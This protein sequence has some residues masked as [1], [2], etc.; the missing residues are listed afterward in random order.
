L[1]VDS[2]V[3]GVGDAGVAES[4]CIPSYIQVF[5]RDCLRLLN[6]SPASRDFLELVVFEAGSQLTYLGENAF[7][8]CSALRRLCFPASVERL[9]SRRFFGC[10]HLS[11]L[12][13]E[14][15]SNLSL[16]TG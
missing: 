5:A 16:I 2:L 8:G 11:Y 4:I 3:H 10:T 12:G 1:S 14:P 9:A 6:G 7:N 13:Y 15:G